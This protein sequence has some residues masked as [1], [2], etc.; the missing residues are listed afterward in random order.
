MVLLYKQTGNIGINTNNPEHLLH[1]VGGNI[2]CEQRGWI[3]D[4]LSIGQDGVLTISSH[5]NA[6][7]SYGT[8]T[9]TLQTSVD[10][11]NPISGN[12]SH[13]DDDWRHIL[14][15]KPI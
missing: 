7:H 11:R 5:N 12:L 4:S 13:H 8:E 2:V 10:W 14:S 15:S 6:V 1:V 3:K 9:V